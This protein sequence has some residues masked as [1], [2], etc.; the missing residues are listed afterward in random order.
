MKYSVFFLLMMIFI[1]TNTRAQNKQ[2]LYTAK[3]TEMGSSIDNTNTTLGNFNTNTTALTTVGDSNN[4]TL[5]FLRTFDRIVKI[6]LAGLLKKELAFE[7]EKPLKD[8]R[9][10]VF[11]TGVKFHPKTDLESGKYTTQFTKIHSTSRQNIFVVIASSNSGSKFKGE[12]RPFA[13]LKNDFVPQ[14]SFQFNNSL[15]FYEKSNGKTK[16]YFEGTVLSSIQ[17]GLRVRDTET[18]RVVSTSSSNSPWSALSLIFSSRSTSTEVLYTQTRSVSDDVR[19][20]GGL[21]IA[22]GTQFLVRQ[23][24][25][26]DLQ[27]ETGSNFINGL[28]KTYDYTNGKLFG[29]VKLMLGLN[30]KKG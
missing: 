4:T 21:A 17:K 3:Y 1:C 28:D 20:S 14:L 26:V 30:Y 9:S 24:V 7:L 8:Y 29:K 22:T 12:K 27:L 15:R 19:I 25:F 18:S 11:R 2:A 10:Y 16:L 13:T 6:D 5:P 23:K